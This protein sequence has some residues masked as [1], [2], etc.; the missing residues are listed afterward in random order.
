[1]LFV[2]KSLRLNNGSPRFSRSTTKRV[3]MV[4]YAAD[5]R[6]INNRL[7]AGLGENYHAHR[8]SLEVVSSVG[9]KY[10]EATILCCRAT[11]SYCERTSDGLSFVGLGPGERTA[12]DLIRT[13]QQLQP[14][15]LILKFPNQD[16]LKWAIQTRTRTALLFADSFPNHTLKHKLKNRLLASRLNNPT[17][18]WVCNHGVRSCQALVP[19]GVKPTKIIPWDWPHTWSGYEAKE[20]PANKT[21][22]SAMFVGHVQEAK[23]VGDLIRAIARLK[24]RGITV[25]LSIAGSGNL[26]PFQSLVQSL[27]ITDLVEFLGLV[28]HSS[29]VGRMRQSDF[30]VVPSRHEYPEGFPLTIYETL[31]S[32]SAL[33][34]SDHPMFLHILEHR[35]NALMFPAGQPDALAECIQTAIAQPDLYKQLSEA[36]HSTWEALQLPVKWGGFIDKWLEDTT[37]SGDYLSSY[38]LANADYSL[39]SPNPGC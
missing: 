36:S 38:T 19:L 6:D 32:R 39:R 4:F 7:Q 1:M 24:A 28:D 2:P 5:Y 3:L 22:Y 25:K 13:I 29:V 14:T 35:V 12:D 10:G 17:V 23:G 18:E 33:I 21:E 15:H 20:L 30:V 11:E 9:Q 26:T 27:D 37:S 8:Y 34:A 16:I 31:N